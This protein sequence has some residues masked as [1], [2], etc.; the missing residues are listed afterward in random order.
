[1]SRFE[2]RFLCINDRNNVFLEISDYVTIIHYLERACSL[3]VTIL[4]TYEYSNEVS[5]DESQV[6]LKSNLTI[7]NRRSEGLKST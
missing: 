2:I 1:M 6:L 5:G 4:L 7:S 3:M